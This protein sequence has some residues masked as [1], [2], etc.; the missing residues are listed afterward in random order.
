MRKNGIPNL[1]NGE[2]PAIQKALPGKG[3]AKAPAEKKK[4]KKDDE[5][6]NNNTAKKVEIKT[7][8]MEEEEQG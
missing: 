2:K 5:E 4:K 3:G 6:D 1:F 8:E 7:E